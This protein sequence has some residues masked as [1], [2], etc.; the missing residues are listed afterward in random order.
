[1]LRKNI[2]FKFCHI[3]KYI[4]QINCLVLNE[5]ILNIIFHN[6]F[7]L[8]ISNMGTFS[9][10]HMNITSHAFIPAVNYFVYEQRLH[11]AASTVQCDPSPIASRFQSTQRGSFQQKTDTWWFKNRFAVKIT[12][13]GPHT[14]LLLT[15]PYLPL[16]FYVT[17]MSFPAFFPD[18]C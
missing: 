5:A 3:S 17:H 1:M 6:Y 2:W 7:T 4:H 18:L 15:L 13:K 11:Y 10:L 9:S 12:F 16:A 8:F 14:F